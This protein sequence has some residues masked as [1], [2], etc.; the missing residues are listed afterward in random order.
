MESK[1]SRFEDLTS[2][3]HHPLTK[4]Y[5]A[6]EQISRHIDMDEIQSYPSIPRMVLRDKTKFIMQL[7]TCLY[8]MKN[9]FQ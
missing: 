2:V 6:F 7:P 3:H 1:N 5:E 9:T 4:K 8:Q